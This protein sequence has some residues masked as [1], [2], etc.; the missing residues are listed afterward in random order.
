MYILL[1]NPTTDFR[2]RTFCIILKYVWSNENTADTSLLQQT[3]VITY[4]FQ[5]HKA[6]SVYSNSQWMNT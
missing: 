1:I 4:T 5:L 2:M 6:H 3:R